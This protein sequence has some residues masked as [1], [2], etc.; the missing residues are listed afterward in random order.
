MGILFDATGLRSRALKGS[1]LH[2][3]GR[4][5]V[6]LFDAIRARAPALKWFNLHVSG[7]FG[8]DAVGLRSVLKSGREWSH[9]ACFQVTFC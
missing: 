8:S 5:W 9:A 3:F 2:G 7:C 6:T 1:R 4:L